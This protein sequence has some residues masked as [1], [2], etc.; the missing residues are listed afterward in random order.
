MKN[1]KQT[2]K[3]DIIPNVMDLPDGRHSLPGF[4]NGFTKRGNEFEMSPGRVSIFVELSAQ[5]AGLMK[6]QEACAAFVS[7]RM[8][9]LEKSQRHWWNGVIED[10]GLTGKP[11]AGRLSASYGGIVTFTPPIADE[12]EE[13][14]GE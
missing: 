6:Y 1:K 13:N 10:L 7:N 11:E 2:T 12:K 3:G 9:E 14:K 5:R 8:V 4:R